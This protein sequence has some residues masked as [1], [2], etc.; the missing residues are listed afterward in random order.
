MLYVGTGFDSTFYSIQKHYNYLKKASLLFV[1]KG[2]K[3]FCMLV[4][5]TP[6]IEQEVRQQF[7][8]IIFISV[9][10]TKMDKKEQAVNSCMQHGAF[11]QYLNNV[12][13]LKEDDYI[14][15]TDVDIRIQRG[16]NEKELE[17]LDQK[18]VL[19][20]YARNSTSTLANI[21]TMVDAR[22]PLY[23]IANR[24]GEV[25]FSYPHYHTPVLG[26]SYAVWKS[27]HDE[28]LQNIERI[29]N[30]FAHYGRQEWL[31]SYILS[32]KGFEIFD[33]SS[34]NIRQIIGSAIFPEYRE[35]TNMHMNSVGTW[36]YPNSLPII[37]AHKVGYPWP[38]GVQSKDNFIITHKEGLA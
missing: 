15:F 20:S 1:P 24:F 10:T 28:Y 26:A 27:I 2:I 9:D 25:I 13:P 36:V 33:P 38:K 31:L 21:V 6:E 37:F 14:I 23:E 8:S 12:S 5:C 7:P 17:L 11:L 18:K 16:F 22:V 32:S 35:S 3:V 30:T 29:N 4:N 19:V 34:I